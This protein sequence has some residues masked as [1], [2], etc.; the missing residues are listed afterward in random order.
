MER[1]MKKK[2]KYLNRFW[3]ELKRTGRA[4]GDTTF[5]QCNCY[6]RPC[7][8]DQLDSVSKTFR[9]QG[10]R[11]TVYKELEDSETFTRIPWVHGYNELD[12]YAVGNQEKIG[13]FLDRFPPMFGFQF[14]Y[15]QA[16]HAIIPESK[17]VYGWVTNENQE[18][19]TGQLWDY[20][21]KPDEKKKIYR[22]RNV[23]NS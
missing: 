21:V 19:S 22:Q 20:I 15:A 7:I 13:W 3:A 5:Y 12:R 17:I 6:L 4:A 10:V 18:V 9:I 11:K 2:V 23:L 16:I 14:G 1:V 8:C